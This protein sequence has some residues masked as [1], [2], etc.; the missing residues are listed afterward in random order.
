MST[1]S[2]FKSVRDVN[3]PFNK[4]ITYTLNRI[5]EGKSESIINQLRLMSDEDYNKNK[6]QLSGV[7]FNGKF[8][9]RS[10]AGLIEHSGFIV[11][12][13]DKLNSIEDAIELRDSISSD[14]YVYAAWVSPSG[15]GLKILV[16]VPAKAENHKGYFES[17][18]KH[19]NH[20]N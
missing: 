2:I 6:S 19:F 5:K 11:L 8:R 4:S 12:D 17:L 20:P 9:N 15:K 7:C 13:I 10:V 1:V 14:E 18:K 16:K 3:S